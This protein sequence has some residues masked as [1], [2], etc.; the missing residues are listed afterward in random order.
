MWPNHRFCCNRP[1]NHAQA[2]GHRQRKRP[3]PQALAATLAPRASAKGSRR[4]PIRRLAY[5][6]PRRR[7][8]WRVYWIDEPL[9][10]A[11]G[12]AAGAAYSARLLS[13][14]NGLHGTFQQERRNLY[15]AGV[16]L[17]GELRQLLESLRREPNKPLLAP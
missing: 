8:A 15:R 3:A 17:L 6:V 7:F 5:H 9:P 13:I 16:R 2:R 4:Q 1:P 10:S 14:Q 11:R 12:R